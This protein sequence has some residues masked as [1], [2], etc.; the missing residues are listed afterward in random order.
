MLAAQLPIL[1]VLLVMGAGAKL[2][3]V[4]TDA[5]PGALTRLGPAVLVP[6]RWRAPALMACAVGE[7][8]LACGLLLTTFP[9]FRYGTALFFALSTYVL[10]ELRRRR[11]DAGCGCF[12]E[13]SSTPVGLRSIGR[14]VVLTGMAVMAIFAP[15]PGWVPFIEP[16]WPLA[17]G[18]AVL[19]VLS[20]ELEEAAHRLRYRAPC[21][22]RPSSEAVALAKLKASGPWRDHVGTLV[23]QEPRDSWREL[24]WRFFAFENRDHQHVVFAVY[25]SGLRPAVR[26]AVVSMESMPE[27]TPVSV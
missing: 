26:V 7:L 3:T 4:R 24:C 6:G 25:L 18:L 16:S 17:A 20:P 19:A 5:T 12:G 9:I 23:S 2:A 10:L 14:T 15:V 22:Q 1:I 8:V 13:V 11:P 27:S 21:E